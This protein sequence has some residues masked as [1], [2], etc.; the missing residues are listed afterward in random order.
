MGMSGLQ[1]QCCASLHTLAAMCL[2]SLHAGDA[3]GRAHVAAGLTAAPRN[4]WGGDKAL[5][6]AQ[7]GI[8]PT[9]ALST[10][11]CGACRPSLHRTRSGKTWRQSSVSTGC[12][13]APCCARRCAAH[14]ASIARMRMVRRTSILTLC[15]AGTVR[16]QP[17]VRA[18]RRRGLP[19]HALHTCHRGRHCCPGALAAHPTAFWLSRCCESWGVHMDAREHTAAGSPLHACVHCMAQ[20]GEETQ[21]AFLAGLAITEP[22][23][24]LLTPVTS[25][26]PSASS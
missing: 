16:Q 2:W 15:V 3:A 20:A 5:S 11:R 21:E 7:L 14:A 24:G 10:S 8:F 23:S 22:Q 25:A 18:L 9:R 13:A 26:L 12:S 19:Q 4:L 6:Q 17:A 1:R